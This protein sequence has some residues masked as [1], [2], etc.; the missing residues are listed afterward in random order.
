MLQARGAE[1]GPAC[2][3]C[4][5][6][7]GAGASQCGAQAVKDIRLLAGAAA[8]AP[9][10]IHHFRL[11][12]RHVLGTQPQRVLAGLLLL[13]AARAARRGRR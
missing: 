8:G 11:E 13:G 4:P 9:Q 1:L 12:R 2:P 7:A 10:L 5:A 3:A 6:G